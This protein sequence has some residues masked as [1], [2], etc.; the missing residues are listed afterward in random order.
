VCVT[1]KKRREC[2]V[3]RKSQERGE[4]ETGRLKR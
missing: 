1:V 2:N 3:K 4:R